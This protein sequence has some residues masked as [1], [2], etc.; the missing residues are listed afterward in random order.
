MMHNANPTDRLRLCLLALLGLGLLWSGAGCASSAVVSTSQQ[1]ADRH[2]ALGDEFYERRRFAE[3]LREW[4]LALALDPDRPAVAER[5]EA[6]GSGKAWQSQTPAA[7]GE[8]APRLRQELEAAEAYYQASQLKEAEVA[9]RRILEW[10]RGQA[11]AAAGLERL[12]AEAYETDSRRA[13]DQMTRELYEQ[14]MRAYRKQA[15]EQ[16]ELKLAEAA[17]LNSDQP[18]VQR[19]LEKVRW[20]LAQQR[21]AATSETIRQQALAAEKAGQWVAAYRHWQVLAQGQTPPPEASQGLDRCRPR[22]D[23]WADGQNAAGRRLLADG[24]LT[25]ALSRFQQVLE[26]LPKNSQALRGQEEARRLIAQTKTQDISKDQGRAHFNAG[27]AA[28]RQGDLTAAIRAWEQAVASAPEDAEYQEWLARAKKELSG[29]D[30]QN[31]QRAEARYAD[32]LAAYQRGELD[33]ALAAWK[34][35]LELD[36]GHEKARL[37][38]QKIEKDSK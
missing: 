19:Y 2:Q 17:K 1:A 8:D 7:V 10:N 28:Y 12:A 18:Q 38:L 4:R 22:V 24:R 35:V 31:R 9:W 29:R 34:E 33:E 37:N 6:V 13:F 15:W 36:P 20:Q 30:T 27:V 23:E 11:E 3:A 5:I 21:Q 26:L 16:A 25:A 14:G 32:G